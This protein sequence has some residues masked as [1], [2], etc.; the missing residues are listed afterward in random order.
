[1][2]KVAR[3]D[4]VDWQ[5]YEEERPAFRARAMAE[6][7]R[8]RVHVG[9][10]LTFLFENALTTRYQVQEMV[11][12]ERIVKEREI[13]HELDTYN[14]LLGGPGDLPA[15]LLIEIDD[16]EERRILLRDWLPP[17]GHL[18][19]RMEDGTKVRALFDPGQVGEGKLSSVQ[20][21]RFPVGGRAPV[22]VGS[23]MRGLF[24]ETEFTPD[25]RRALAEDLAE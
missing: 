8:R 1:M 7:S 14:A 10:R 12:A 11:R 23:D 6:K 16:P 2:R 9:E 20:Y 19:V 25:Q 13:R 4:V 24:K 17:P 5:T 15:T 18:F 3:E 22:A 21:L